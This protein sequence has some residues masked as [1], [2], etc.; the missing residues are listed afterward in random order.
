VSAWSA[1]AP[2]NMGE[3]DRLSFA[4]RNR[5]G[6]RLF[7]AIIGLLVFTTPYTLPAIRL[8]TE[9]GTSVGSVAP[10]RLPVLLV[11]GVGF[12]SLGVPKLP[13]AQSA[14]AASQAASAPQTS[15]HPPTSVQQ[16]RVPDEDEGDHRRG[17]GRSA[18]RHRRH[19]RRRAD[20]YLGGISL[21]SGCSTGRVNSPRWNVE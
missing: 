3:F 4:G 10:A 20:R 16:I 21:H 9:T 1:A 2:S 5:R 7:F 12:P 18:S 14:A 8:A 17:S 15:H 13:T 11:P 6:A 19:D